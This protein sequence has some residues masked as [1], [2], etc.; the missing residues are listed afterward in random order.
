MCAKGKAVFV[1]NDGHMRKC[2]DEMRWDYPSV[3]VR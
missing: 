1:E 2:V 3:R